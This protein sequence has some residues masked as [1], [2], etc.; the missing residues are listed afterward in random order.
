MYVTLTQSI[1]FKNRDDTL[2]S[3]AV[4]KVPRDYLDKELQCIIERIGNPELQERIFE[5]VKDP[6]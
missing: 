6:R 4:S 5:L 1:I 3:L 2:Q